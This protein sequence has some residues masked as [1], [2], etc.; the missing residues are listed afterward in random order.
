MDHLEAVL[1]RPLLDPHWWPSYDVSDP[2]HLHPNDSVLQVHESSAGRTS[3]VD[4]QQQS[5]NLSGRTLDW[6]REIEL[7]KAT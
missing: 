5:L 7:N 2:P 3:L 6:K 1:N 4:V